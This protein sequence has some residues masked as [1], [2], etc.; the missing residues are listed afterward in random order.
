MNKQPFTY[1]SI[2]VS[3]LFILLAAGCSNPEEKKTAH[4][5]KGMEYQEKGDNNA[6]ILEFKNAVQ[7]DPKV[8]PC[9][10]SVGPCIS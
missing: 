10:L 8:C 1:I 3:I 5:Q 7:V 4:Y 6:A 9:P 2:I